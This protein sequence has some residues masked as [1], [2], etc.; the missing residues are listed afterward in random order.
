LAAACAFPCD[1]ACE[2]DLALAAGGGFGWVFSGVCANTW[3]E[4]APSAIAAATT[5]PTPIF[6][7][8][9]TNRPHLLDQY[10]IAVAIFG[11]APTSRRASPKMQR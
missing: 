8:L 9:R 11:P 5:N 1:L 3:A 7:V 2:V 10:A 6:E 4:P